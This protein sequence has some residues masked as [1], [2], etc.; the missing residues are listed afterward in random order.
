[1]SA[2]PTPLRPFGRGRVL[3]PTG[4]Q[5]AAF[6]R[7]AI[8]ER[9]VPERTLMEN[10]GRSAAL[11]LDRLY[12]TGDVV[13]LVGSGNNGGDAL[14]LLRSLAAWGR[15]VTAVLAGGREPDP[16]LLHAL[17][18]PVLRP[19][20][21]E[22]EEAL[23]RIAGA[24]V[25]VD[26]LLGTG[27]RGAPRDPVAT[28]IGWLNGAGRPVL[29]LDVPSGVDADSGAVPGA[30]VRADVTV[31]LGWPKLGV[32]FHPA[33]ARAGRIVVVEIGFPPVPEGTFPAALITPGW[34]VFHRPRRG[35]DTHKNQVGSLLLLAGREGMGGAAVLAARAALR[36]GV[37]LLRVASDPANREILQ[38]TV[39]EA[40]FVDASDES[41]LQE[42]VEGSAAVAAG[43]GLGTGSSARQAL[44]VVATSAPRPTVLDADALN[45]ASEG[46]ELSVDR[47]AGRTPLVVTPHP[48]EMAR[49]TGVPAEEIVGRRAEEARV[50]GAEWGCTVL[51]KGTPS[52]VAGPHGEL[53]VDTFGSSDLASAG[54]GDVLTGAT[55]AFLAQGAPPATAAGLA[56]AT[57][58]RAAAMGQEGPGLVPSDVVDRIPA[59]LEEGG[60]GVTD[61]DFPFLLFDQDPPR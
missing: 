59:A 19:G 7:F 49:L 50:R 34:S 51:L 53:L 41:A 52:V 54:L 28:A 32:L 38:T 2:E 3:A 48:G 9:G 44:G 22:G 57:T 55:G 26:G 17:D 5:S 15:S 60:D 13:A 11:V 47:W 56:L 31:C 4:T 29:A 21:G 30:A 40:I 12:G 8:Q 6:D 24:G 35:P 46:G 14:V 23:R 45:L 39:P 37:G 27:I 1:M 58:G 20:A 33:R 16:G 43:P 25:L 61:L 36:S 10:A 42:A 18:L